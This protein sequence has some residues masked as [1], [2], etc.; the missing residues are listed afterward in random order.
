M[1]LFLRGHKKHETVV[2]T[3]L[4][5]IA[6][7]IRETYDPLM[8]TRAMEG[9]IKAIS[10]DCDAVFIFRGGMWEEI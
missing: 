10:E 1:N 2:V 7:N 5:F 8:G 4:F 6:A 9:K 3:T